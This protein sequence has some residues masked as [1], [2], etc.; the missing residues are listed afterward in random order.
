MVNSVAL[1]LSFN[2]PDLTERCVQSVQKYFTNSS[3]LLVHNGSEIKVVQQLKQKFPTIIHLELDKNIGYAGGMNSGLDFFSHYFHQSWCLV[4]TND[5]ELVSFNPKV[6]LSNADII[7][8]QIFFRSMKKLDSWGGWYSLKKGKLFHH[9]VLDSQVEDFDK[10]SF[11]VPGTAFFLHRQVLEKKFKFDE[12][13]FMFWEDVYLSFVLK[14]KGM[15]LTR[16]PLIILKHGGGKTTK[17]NMHYTSY[18]YQRNRLRVAPKMTTS[19]RLKVIL[20]IYIVLD[21]VLQI[22]K[23]I[24]LGDWKRGKKLA[25]AI[26]HGLNIRNGEQ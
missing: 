21:L 11:Y 13:L 15:I 26:I 8:P 10:L 19:P 4:V 22:L 3:I 25:L 6:E 12:S 24:L 23:K 14:T 7:A 5:T 18:Y 1:I 16:T 17:K 20:Q 9:K 2:H